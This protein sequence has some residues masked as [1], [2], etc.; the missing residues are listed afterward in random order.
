[1]I[2]MFSLIGFLLVWDLSPINKRLQNCQKTTRLVRC[3]K[4][5]IAFRFPK[6]GVIAYRNVIININVSTEPI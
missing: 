4:N 6:I 2:E 1:M 3:N 5:K